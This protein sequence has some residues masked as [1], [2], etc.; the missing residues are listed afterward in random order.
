MMNVE[1]RMRSPRL[2]LLVFLALAVA[3]VAL[4]LDF[5]PWI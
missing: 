4:L 2:T 5:R 3:M 1:E